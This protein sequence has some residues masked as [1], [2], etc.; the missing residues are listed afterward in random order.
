MPPPFV[1]VIKRRPVDPGGPPTLTGWQLNAL[2]P[3]VIYPQKAPDPIRYGD[4]PARPAKQRRYGY[5]AKK[6]IRAVMYDAQSGVLGKTE[7]NQFT[8]SPQGKS[9]TWNER[10]NIRRGYP[11]AY[12]TNFDLVPQTEDE[13][14]LRMMLGV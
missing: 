1:A 3:E 12:G 4:T 7:F 9:L 10:S 11:R 2:L 6:Q 13:A 14:H 8:K 5:L